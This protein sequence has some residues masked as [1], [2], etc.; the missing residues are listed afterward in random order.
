MSPIIQFSKR[1]LMRGKVITPGWFRVKIE[2]VGEQ[3]AAAKEGR[4]PSTNYP[5]EGTILYNADTGDKEFEGCAIDWNFNSGAM[6][7]ARGFLEALGQTPEENKRYELAAA[8]GKELDVFVENDI[9]Q[10]RQVNRVNHKYRAPRPV[11][12]SNVA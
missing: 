1:D 2:S 10:G 11:E 8:E 5:V 12:G 4:A 6:G 3:P 7:F 9:Y